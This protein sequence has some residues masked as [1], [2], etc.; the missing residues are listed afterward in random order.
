[1]GWRSRAGTGWGWKVGLV[2]FGL[3]WYS[4]GWVERIGL[5]GLGGCGGVEGV[6]L[7]GVGGAEF[8]DEV[9]VFAYLVIDSA[10][11]V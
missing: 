4:K 3:V 6:G 5:D 10:Q 1:M 7:G 8:G 11:R 2:W 9:E